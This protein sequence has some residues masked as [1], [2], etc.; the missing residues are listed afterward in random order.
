MLFDPSVAGNAP[1]AREMELDRSSSSYVVKRAT[2]NGNCF[3]NGDVFHH[4]TVIST[5]SHRKWEFLKLAA[6]GNLPYGTEIPGESK[7]S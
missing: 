7:K 5:A 3:F 1:V 6:R 2:K 4:L